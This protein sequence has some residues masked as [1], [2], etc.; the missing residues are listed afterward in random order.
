MTDIRR[1]MM[2]CETADI[3]RIHTSRTKIRKFE[4]TTYIL[5]GIGRK[6]NGFWWADRDTWQKFTQINAGLIKGL[7]RNKGKKFEYYSYQVEIDRNECR[8]LQLT[9]WD[10]ILE[11]TVHYGATLAPYGQFFWQ[12]DPSQYDPDQDD[13]LKKNNVCR[14]PAIRWSK[15]MQDYDAIEI[16]NYQKNDPS[17]PRVEWLDIDWDVPSGCAWRLKGISIKMIE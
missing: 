15:V 8:L 9:T 5:Q 10:A 7:P 1:W 12:I 14:V 16:P 3:I 17:R 6:P 4:D 13:M 11:F 2:L